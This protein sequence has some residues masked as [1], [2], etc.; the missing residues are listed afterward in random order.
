MSNVPEEVREAM[1]TAISGAPFASSRALGKVDAALSALEAAG[2]VCVPVEASEEM[3][4][5][6]QCLTGGPHYCPNCASKMKSSQLWRAML[7]ASRKEK[8]DV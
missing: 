8:P 4:E 3:D 2:W 5:A 7:T 6:I 1:A